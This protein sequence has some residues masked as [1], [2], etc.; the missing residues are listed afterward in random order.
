MR[1]V[2]RWLTKIAFNSLVVMLIRLNS[3][4][5]L[6]LLKNVLFLISSMKFCAIISKD[7]AKQVRDHECRLMVMNAFGFSAMLV[8]SVIAFANI[9]YAF[10]E[11]PF[12][13]RYV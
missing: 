2:Y 9:N 7:L 8:I 1:F 5:R 3:L 12:A 11:L 10:D 4:L 13:Y 6:S